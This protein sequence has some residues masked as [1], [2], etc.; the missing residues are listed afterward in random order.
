MIEFWQ[1]WINMMGY[2]KEKHEVRSCINV[3]SCFGFQVANSVSS[4]HTVSQIS[5]V[6]FKNRLGVGFCRPYFH[7]RVPPWTLVPHLLWHFQFTVQKYHLKHS[8]FTDNSVF[9]SYFPKGNLIF[10]SKPNVGNS[11][12][13]GPNLSHTYAIIVLSKVMFSYLHAT[14]RFSKQ[15]VWKIS[16]KK[17]ITS[18]RKEIKWGQCI[19][20]PYKN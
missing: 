17:H 11:L 15:V 14:L 5:C 10:Y 2:L 1:K 3:S 7:W 16:L 19:S 18:V 9:P 13:K 4:K 8:F 6:T 12:A 20:N